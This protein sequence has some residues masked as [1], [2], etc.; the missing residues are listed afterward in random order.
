MN[1]TFEQLIDAA[2]INLD[3]AEEVDIKYT[4][5][6]ARI[7]IGQALIAIA[8]ELKRVNDKAD[9]K[10]KNKELPEIDKDLGW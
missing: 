6:Y 5:A 1:A 2:K 4:A 7:A 3:R 9:E 10:N 8:L